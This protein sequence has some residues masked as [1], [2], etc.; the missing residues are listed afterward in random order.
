MEF[1]LPFVANI[2]KIM[3]L[4]RYFSLLLILFS[5]AG[6]KSAREDG[7]EQITS[8]WDLPLS[9]FWVRCRAPGRGWLQARF[10][11]PKCEHPRLLNGCET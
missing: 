11:M 6:C 10:H 9:V 1:S 4:L 3:G 2:W 8:G 5:F 7:S